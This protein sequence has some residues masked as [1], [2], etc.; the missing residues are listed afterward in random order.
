MKVRKIFTVALFV[1][2]FFVLP[3]LAS[4][5]YISQNTQ[6]ANT[7]KDVADAYSLAWFK[8][9]AN[10][11][12]GSN[13]IR[14]GVTVH[15]CGVITNSI[16]ILAGGTPNNPIIFYFEPNA[17]FSAPTWTSGSII[18]ANYYTPWITIDGGSN[19]VIQAT[20]NGTGLAYSNYITAISL[21]ECSG[22][23]VKNLTI[24]NLY[25]RTA[26]A[27]EIQ[28]G[29]GVRLFWNGGNPFSDDIVTNCVFHDM[30]IGFSIAYSPSCSDITMTHCKAYHCNWGGNASDDNS[31]TTLNGLTV[32]HCHFYS[33]TNWD[34]PLDDNHH[35]GFYAWA[36]TGGS[37]TNVIY[38]DNYVG[39]GYGHN[40]SGLFV[41]GIVYSALAYNN[42]FDSS[43]GTTPADGQLFYWLHSGNTPS[44]AMAYNNTFIGGLGVNFFQGFGS[45]LT[46]YIC[47]NNA[48]FTRKL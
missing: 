31:S 25:V 46:T 42:I 5:I 28:A 41:S 45:N 37:L 27:E 11:G 40:S 33:W 21:Q 12:N 8:T 36:E 17:M 39:P 4:D 26:G 32:D 43:D 9:P 6:G 16:T 44:I 14:P 48:S 2:F 3:C 10:W 29:T 13:Q 24:Q 38:S 35:N 20:A 47:K 19:G 22:V 34:D 18:S 1:G 7:G 23:V 15:F 30:Y